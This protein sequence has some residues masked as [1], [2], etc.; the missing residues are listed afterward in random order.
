M[1]SW[2]LP[3]IIADGNAEELERRREHLPKLQTW[4]GET[5]A[6]GTARMGPIPR[7]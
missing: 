7:L 6:G 5:D 4:D 1:K 2:S 3:W